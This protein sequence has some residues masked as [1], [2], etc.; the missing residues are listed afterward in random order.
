[1]P[2]GREK[3]QVNPCG[4]HLT[5]CL[6]NLK[7]RAVLGS[8]LLTLIPGSFLS[9]TDTERAS[10]KRWLFIACITLS[11]KL[12][13]LLRLGTSLFRY[14]LLPGFCFFFPAF[15]NHSLTFQ[16]QPHR[17]T[18][19]VVSVPFWEPSLSFPTSLIGLWSSLTL[20]TLVIGLLETQ[21]I[22]L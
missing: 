22:Y 9:P 1:M 19:S 7:P 4:G 11:R 20:F 8:G 6:W 2:S 15:S 14:L 12:V 21:C 16:I 18:G 13:V 10:L 3:S 5:P 17:H